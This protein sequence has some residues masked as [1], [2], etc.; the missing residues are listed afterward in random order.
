[1]EWKNPEKVEYGVLYP[2]LRD[3]ELNRVLPT[4]DKEE[5]IGAVASFQARG[6]ESRLVKRT[7]TPW[8]VIE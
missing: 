7:I 5:A 3:G 1:M 4:G 8:E 6:I 2:H